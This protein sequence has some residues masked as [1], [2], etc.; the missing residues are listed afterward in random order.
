SQLSPRYEQLQRKTVQRS[1]RKETRYPS[2]NCKGHNE[3]PSE[4]NSPKLKEEKAIL[5]QLLQELAAEYDAIVRKWPS[6]EEKE[7]SYQKP[8]EGESLRLACE[9]W[10]RRVSKF[11]KSASKPEEPTQKKLTKVQ[12]VGNGYQSEIEKMALEWKL[13][14]EKGLEKAWSK[15]MDEFKH[16]INEPKKKKLSHLTDSKEPRDEAILVQLWVSRLKSVNSKVEPPCLNRNLKRRRIKF[17]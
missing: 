14:S 17:G 8:L 9:N 13:K 16:I 3:E 5:D 4:S 2:C 10:T 11:Q 15:K 6:K 12:E 7:G 1:L